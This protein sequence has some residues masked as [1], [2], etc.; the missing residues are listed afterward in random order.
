MLKTLF[1]P[2]FTKEEIIK[3]L[4][5]VYH[6]PK[7]QKLEGAIHSDEV[8]RAVTDKEYQKKLFEEF[9]L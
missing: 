3:R 2:E 6:I 1:S 8:E 9:G 5:E 7:N 4:E